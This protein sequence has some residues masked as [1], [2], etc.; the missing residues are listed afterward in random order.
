MAQSYVWKVS[1]EYYTKKYDWSSYR[2][3]TSRS[4]VFTNKIQALKFANQMENNSNAR[5]VEVRKWG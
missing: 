1:Y 3:W 5:Y 2:E 4:R